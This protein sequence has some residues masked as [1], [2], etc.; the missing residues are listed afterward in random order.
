MYIYTY[1]NMETAAIINSCNV[2]GRGQ[3]WAGQQHCEHAEQKD[4]TYCLPSGPWSVFVSWLISLDF[5]FFSPSYI[6]ACQSSFLLLLLFTSVCN[7]G[8]H[9]SYCHHSPVAVLDTEPL[10]IPLCTLTSVWNWKESFSQLAVH[11]YQCRPPWQLTLP[12]I[13]ARAGLEMLQNSSLEAATIACGPAQLPSFTVFISRI[14]AASIWL[15]QIWKC[16]FQSCT[17]QVC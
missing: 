15:R 6:V 13:I 9:S 5:F 17:S 7:S 4:S 3:H 14:C 2:V 8:S 16:L 1:I 12:V 11:R 10:K